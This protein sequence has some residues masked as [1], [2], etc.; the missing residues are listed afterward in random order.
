M[1]PLPMMEMIGEQVFKYAL[2]LLSTTSTKSTPS[3]KIWSQFYSNFEMGKLPLRSRT[4][5]T[6][7]NCNY[8]SARKSARSNS[9]FD[10]LETVTAHRSPQT[11]YRA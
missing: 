3:R 10:I 7:F 2:P 5:P 9:M 4:G 11:P 8:R 6:F 1:I